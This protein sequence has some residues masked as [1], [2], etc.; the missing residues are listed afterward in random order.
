LHRR[1]TELDRWSDILRGFLYAPFGGVDARKYQETTA[2]DGRAM[3]PSLGVAAVWP[4]ADSYPGL[5]ARCRRGVLAP[6]WLTTLFSQVIDVAMSSHRDALALDAGSSRA[7]PF[8]DIS[9]GPDNALAALQGFVS[10][11]R[12]ADVAR[13]LLLPRAVEAVLAQPAASVMKRVVPHPHA[14]DGEASVAPH[15]VPPSAA[16]LIPPSNIESIARQLRSS[17]VL[18]VGT[19]NGEQRGGT[20][21]AA[22]GAGLIVT[23][24]HVVEDLHDI[25]VQLSDGRTIPAEVL[26]LSDTTDLA[27]LRIDEGGLVGIRRGDNAVQGQ[28]VVSLGFSGLL[29]GEPSLS[30]GIV[31]AT[32]RRIALAGL[33]KLG[34][35]DVIQVDYRTGGGA[36]GS[37]I[38]DMEGNLVGVHVAGAAVDDDVIDFG[39]RFAVPV[40]DVTDFLKSM[41]AND[42]LPEVPGIHPPVDADVGLAVGSD[43]FNLPTADS[44]TMQAFGREPEG[45]NV[46][47]SWLLRE[48]IDQAAPLGTYVHASDVHLPRQVIRN[49]ILYAVVGIGS[50]ASPT[51]TSGKL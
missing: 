11:G 39:P 19:T 36:S 38:V 28:P 25:E 22:N 24:R 32:E 49:G 37:P 20:G 41:S 2:I 33:E 31:T 3:P 10:R 4:S 9:T 23:N 21:W 16:W 44:F 50:V 14:A 42:P 15:S 7:D 48:H 12:H 18:V 8:N 26:G 51:D 13:T 5:V 6:S 46:E 17:V 45:E 34:R 29:E 40:A 27:A 30:W 43:W 1:C 35:I 47:F